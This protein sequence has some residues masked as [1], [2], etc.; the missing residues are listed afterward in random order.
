MLMTY[1]G[2]CFKNKIQNI[3]E[4]K[5]THIKTKYTYVT[6]YTLLCVYIILF[7]M[8]SYIYLYI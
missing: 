4:D 6:N 8:F 5:N 1:T 2:N 7:T 3:L